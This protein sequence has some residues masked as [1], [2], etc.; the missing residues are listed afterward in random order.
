MNAGLPPSSRS[1]TPIVNST[2]S[3]FDWN[4]QLLRFANRIGVYLALTHGRYRCTDAFILVTDVYPPV[5]M[6]P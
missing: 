6:R 1:T 4:L 3:W 5:Q 2:V